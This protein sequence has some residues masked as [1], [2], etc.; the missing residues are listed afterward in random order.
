MW[1][2]VCFQPNGLTTAQLCSGRHGE[3][4]VRVDL[5]NAEERAAD[6]FQSGDYSRLADFKVD[7]QLM[8]MRLMMTKTR[9]VI[10]SVCRLKSLRVAGGNWD[11]RCFKQYQ[12]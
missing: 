2:N 4:E 6:I 1:S 12:D 5:V 8:G 10:N 11:R 9:L 3:E 7:Q